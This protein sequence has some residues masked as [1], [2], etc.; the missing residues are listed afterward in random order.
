MFS[1]FQTLLIIAGIPLSAWSMQLAIRFILFTCEPDFLD[2]YEGAAPVTQVMVGVPEMAVI[3]GFDQFR[4]H[5]V[6]LCLRGFP[7]PLPRWFPFLYVYAVLCWGVAAA[8]AL[9]LLWQI[10]AAFSLMVCVQLVLLSMG[11]LVMIGLSVPFSALDFVVTLL[12]SHIARKIPGRA[13]R[14]NT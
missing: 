2:A 7:F 3:S 5:C 8:H 9:F 4:R 14:N 1:R 12:D 6:K 10:P 11:I 13:R